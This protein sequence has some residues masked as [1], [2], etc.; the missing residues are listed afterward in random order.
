MFVHS[1]I[2]NTISKV[3]VNIC[4]S[5]TSQNPYVYTTTANLAVGTHKARHVLDKT[6]HGQTH[7]AT[8][9]YLAPH[10]AS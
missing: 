10:I 8:E 3:L 7:L 6:Q 9:R 4:S 2:E 5:Q 1:Y